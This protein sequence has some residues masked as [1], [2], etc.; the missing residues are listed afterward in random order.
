MDYV[1]ALLI[2]TQRLRLVERF[3]LLTRIVY[4]VPCDDPIVTNVDSLTTRLE[5]NNTYDRNQEV[6]VRHYDDELPNPNQI[7]ARVF[8]L[9]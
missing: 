9:Q 3:L 2:G 1:I 5:N 4:H 8:R 7:S 6:F